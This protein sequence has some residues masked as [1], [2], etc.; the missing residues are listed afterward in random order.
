MNTDL[1]ILGLTV[2]FTIITI[3]GFYGQHTTAKSALA[4]L[5]SVAL[6]T[7]KVA[8]VPFST[9]RRSTL[10]N[11]GGACATVNKVYV[12]KGFEKPLATALLRHEV[13][14]VKQH[15]AAIRQGFNYIVAILGFTIAPVYFYLLDSAWTAT[16]VLVGVNVIGTLLTLALMQITEVLADRGVKTPETR[17]AMADYLMEASVGVGKLNRAMITQRA[18]FL[19]K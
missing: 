13:T 9:V 18:K 14:H 4:T 6:R 10:E 15:H 16:A 5:D 7:R 17:D 1:L 2:L 8:G 11:Y 19:R 12:E 3:A